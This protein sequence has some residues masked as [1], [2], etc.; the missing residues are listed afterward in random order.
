MRFRRSCS[1]CVI[2]DDRSQKSKNSLCTRRPVKCLR[3]SRS[4]GAYVAINGSPNVRELN[5]CLNAIPW[6]SLFSWA[7]L[8]LVFGGF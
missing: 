1:R 7:D 8:L 5:E 2:T 3:C 6:A 4:I